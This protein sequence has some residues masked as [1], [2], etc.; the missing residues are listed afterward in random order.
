M[1]THLSTHYFSSGRWRH[2]HWTSRVVRIIVGLL[3]VGHG[4]QKLFGVVGGYGVSGTG[5]AF[6]SMGMRPGKLNAVAAG[7]AELRPACC[8]RLAC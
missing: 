3:F 5:A 7:A 4:A 2:G 6:E 8:W 1:R